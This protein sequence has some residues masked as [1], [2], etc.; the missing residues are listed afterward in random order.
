MALTRIFAKGS[1]LRHRVCRLVDMK[2]DTFEAQHS[3]AVGL[4]MHLAL[5][6]LASKYELNFHP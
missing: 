6:L 4:S 3:T 2:A 5:G 1:R